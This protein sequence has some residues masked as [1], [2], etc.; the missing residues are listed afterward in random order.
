MPKADIAMYSPIILV[1]GLALP[2]LVAKWV[3]KDPIKMVQWGIFL[4]L[5]TSSLGW[6][7]V[8]TTSGMATFSPRLSLI[9]LKEGLS[10]DL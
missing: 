9:G 5:I 7:V 6:I 10:V 4:K 8:R 2:A 3:A 1:M